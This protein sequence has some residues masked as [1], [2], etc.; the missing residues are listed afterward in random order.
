MDE[1]GVPSSKMER[2]LGLDGSNGCTAIRTYLM[3]LNCTLKMVKTIHDMLCVLYHNK[4]HFKKNYWRK[5][6][7]GQVSVRLPVYLGV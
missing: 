3:S 5:C 1:Q 7:P 4:K 2:A 6:D